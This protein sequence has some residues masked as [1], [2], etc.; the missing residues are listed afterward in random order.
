MCA[1]LVLWC[2]DSSALTLVNIC[3]PCGRSEFP[4]GIW[5]EETCL[6]G[7]QSCG[8]CSRQDQNRD[9]RTESSV[10]F[11]T[12]CD[13][14]GNLECDWLC[15]ASLLFFSCSLI[16]KEKEE[17]MKKFKRKCVSASAEHRSVHFRLQIAIVWQLKNLYV[18]KI[19]CICYVKKSRWKG[20]TLG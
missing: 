3:G 2:D 5:L 15:F 6:P 13:A 17:V 7:T 12:L 16:Q 14:A 19:H 8:G 10:M 9:V 11:Y 4:W 18:I 20:K 1:F